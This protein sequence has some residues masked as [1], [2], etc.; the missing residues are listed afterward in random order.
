MNIKPVY[1]FLAKV[2]ENAYLNGLCNVFVMLL[3]VSLMSAFTMLLGNGAML[4]GL[5]GVSAFLI[6]TSGL[7]WKLFPFLLVVYFSNFLSTYHKFSRATII[8]PAL[9]I[10]VILCSEWGWLHPGTVSPTNYPLAIIVPLLVCFSVRF[11]HRHK[12]FLESELP[13]VVDQ[14]LNLVGATILLVAFYSLVGYAVKELVDVLGGI[15][16]LIPD[17]NSYALSDALIYE[18]LRNLFWSMG[19]NG[20]IIFSPYKSELYEFT[21]QSYELHETMGAPLPIL[22]SNFYDI[23]AGMGGAGNCMSLVLCMLLF[24]RNRGYRTL[25]A[26]VLVL[27]IFNI[28]EPILFGLPVIFN[29]VLVIPFLTVPLVSLTVAY[30]ATQQGWVHPVSEIISWMTPPLASGYIA[31]GHDWSAVG[32]QI[33]I[34][35]IGILIYYP[36]FK[37]MDKVVGSHTV[38][39]KGMSDNFFNYQELGSSRNVMGLLPQMSSN[40]AAQ[41]HVSDLQKNGDFILFYQ[42]QYDCGKDCIAS[43]EVLIRH[44]SNDGV[45]SPPSFLTSFAKLGLNSEMDMWVLKTALEEVAPLA[46][47]PVFRIS[48]NISPETFLVPDFAQMVIKLIKRSALSFNQVELEITEELL[49]QDEITTWAVFQEL[50]SY[51]IKIALDDFGSGYSSIGYLSKFEFD[52]VKIDRSLVLNLKRKN[53]REMF[54][55]TSKLVK[56]TGADT[57]VEGVEAR[58]DVEFILEQGIKLIQGYYFYKPMPFEDVVANLNFCCSEEDT[59]YEHYTM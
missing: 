49:I 40:L 30:F 58:E 52:K 46:K 5:E 4:L 22:T 57:V 41:R 45:I 51:G 27:S 2:S 56:L 44:R 15:S 11:M 50:R 1:F 16:R 24:T 17:L 29:P 37:Q 33:I 20:H 26:A 3:P 36:F 42:P 59:E 35:V 23:Y 8:T 14:S 53:G 48:I 34:L 18:F 19:I 6:N 43:L 21:R 25:A 28:N 13:N 38:F 32:L 10:Y 9:L 39:S 47:N 31:T 55:L 54:R 7:T 12:V